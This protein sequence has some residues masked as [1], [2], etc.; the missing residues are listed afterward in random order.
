[1]NVKPNLHPVIGDTRSNK[2]FESQNCTCGTPFTTLNL[3]YK[4]ELGE[5]FSP[6]TCRVCLNPECTLHVNLDKLGH[7]KQLPKDYEFIVPERHPD[8]MITNPKK[9]HKYVEKPTID[10]ILGTDIL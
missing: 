4:T 10:N 9:G 1:M 3:F 7:W 2:G 5:A 8:N 6:Q